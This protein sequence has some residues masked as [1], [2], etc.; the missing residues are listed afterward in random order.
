MNKMTKLMTALPALALLSACAT[1][2]ETVPQQTPTTTPAQQ[3][4]GVQYDKMMPERYSCG[5]AGDIMAKQSL[6]K[7][8][9]MLTATLPS[10]KFDQQSIILN[11]ATAEVGTRYVN[12]A[13]P[14]ATIQW[15]M[16]DDAALFA[17]DWANGQNYKAVC[18][19]L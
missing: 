10:L 8:Q 13:N 11:K 19:K 3:V 4:T 18:K 5:D 2:P 9:A 1:S 16:K 12:D 7:E 6:N 15:Q 14:D 17:V